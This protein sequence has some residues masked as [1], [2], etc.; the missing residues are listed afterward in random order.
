M[1]IFFQITFCRHCTENI[2]QP[3]IDVDFLV[4]TKRQTT[5]TGACQ[6]TS[7]FASTYLW[8]SPRSTLMIIMEYLFSEWL[9]N[10]T[11]RGFFLP[12]AV[13]MI[14]VLQEVNKWQ[15][16]R[17]VAVYPS[18]APSFFLLLILFFLKH[19]FVHG[20]PLFVLASRCLWFPFKF[21]TIMIV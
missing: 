4:R 16:F 5:G 20:F 18:A 14:S 9:I 13:N 17:P 10:S 12:S 3:E 15:H 7:V 11:F 8:S 2:S 21:A 1:S 19:V 6:N